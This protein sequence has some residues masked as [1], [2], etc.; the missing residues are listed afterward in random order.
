MDIKKLLE[1]SDPLITAPGRNGR[2]QG[3]VKN[4]LI[5]LAQSLDQRKTAGN[6]V[7]CRASFLAHLL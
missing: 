3:E 1:D 5:M 4:I 6:R 2:P 7:K